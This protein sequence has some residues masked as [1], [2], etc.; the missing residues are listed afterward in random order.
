MLRPPPTEGSTRLSLV[1][2]PIG[3]L[4]DIT[5]RAL[6]TL[7]SA[8]AILCEDTRRTLKLLSHHQIPRPSVYFACHEHNE[9]QMVDRVLG[10]LE[11]GLSV[12]YCTDAGTPLVSDPG[13]LLAREARAR[14]FVVE[15]IPGPSAVDTALLASGLPVSAFTFKGFSPRKGGQRRR[16]LDED[17][18]SRH[19]LVFFEAPYRL[20]SFLCL[21]VEVYGP[22]RQAA[23]CFELT[24]LFERVERGTLLELAERLGTGKI[25]GEITV[26]IEGR[27]RRVRNLSEE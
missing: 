2:T 27:S 24:K 12:A 1:A 18:R 22:D 11:S 4:G 3:N 10:L 15:V 25:Q 26:V 13:F 19:T 16:F 7:R 20:H 9:R 21:A 14:G 23:V 6:E 8:R 17:R 5:L